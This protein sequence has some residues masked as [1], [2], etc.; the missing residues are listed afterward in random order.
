MSRRNSVECRVEGLRSRYEYEPISFNTGPD[1]NLVLE[2][3]T[4]PEGISP[5]SADLLD[6]AA[7]IY[8]IERQLRRK[9]TSPP[10]RFT[11]SMQ[12]RNPKAWNDEA[13]AASQDI[14]SLLGDAVW[15]LDFKPGLRA[16]VPEHQRD[17][18]RKPKQV[19]MLSG[20]MDSTCGAAT[21]KTE[22]AETQPVSFYTL[23]KGLQKNI[24]SDLGYDRL[25]QW[26]MKWEGEVGRGYSFYYRSFLF[27]SLGAA[28]AESWRVRTILQFENGVLA[29]SVPPSAYWLMTKHA[30]PLLHSHAGRLFSA[31][32]GGE[33]K[34]SNPFLL[35]TKRGCVQEAIK[36]I[37]KTKAM[38]LLRKTETCWYYRANRVKGG[39]KRPGVPCGVCIPCIVRRT[40][41]PDEKYT[42]DLLKDGNKNNQQ[43]G[44]NFRSY[45][46]FLD[47]V[48]K[49]K[50][51]PGDFYAILPP[52]GRELVETNSLSL[53]DLHQLFLKFGKEFMSTFNL[54]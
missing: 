5:T 38:Q 22:A 4:G 26:R 54:A 34:I 28:I 18:R 41:M 29:T 40:A 32:F 47:Q 25:N 17:G 45:Y 33:W 9:S 35:L 15:E 3:E 42:Y 30:H 27:L 44:E 6:F 23:Q 51:A 50:R 8:Q 16:P 7:A 37:G 13:I 31:L 39:K 43:R 12:L 53:D 49:T 14:L 20:G 1:L 19:L 10:E 52:S 36:A 46:I 24:A 2:G 21:I 11:L 48:L